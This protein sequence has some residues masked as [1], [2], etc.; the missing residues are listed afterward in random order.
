[1]HAAAGSRVIAT[2]MN[3]NEIKKI[4]ELMD[5]NGLVE[6]EHE[7]EGKRIKLRRA[8]VGIV[9]VAPILPVSPNGPASVMPTP[10]PAAPKLPPNVVEFKSPLVGTFYRA[11]KPDEDDFVNPGDEVDAE[12]VICIIEAMKVMNEIK[13]EMNGIVKEVLVKNGQAVEF[14]EPLFLIEK[15]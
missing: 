13:A 5:E 4:I 1:M 9:P 11:P 7:E 10:E 3:L 8:E 2:G 12:K 15:K 6:F 14:G